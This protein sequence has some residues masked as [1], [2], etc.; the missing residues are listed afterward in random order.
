MMEQN[1]IFDL[2]GT[3]VDS[4]PGIEYAVDAVLSRSRRRRTQDLRTLIGPPI[5]SILQSLT[6][7]GEDELNDLERGFRRSYDAV[8]WRKTLCYA[9]VCDTL[10]FLHA[11]GKRLF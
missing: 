6:N 2:D 8:G 9:G 4:L 10:R 5:R 3:L 1:F 11:Q 7:A